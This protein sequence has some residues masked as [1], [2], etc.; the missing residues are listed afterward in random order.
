MS[1][2]A[3]G[4]GISQPSRSA[5]FEVEL[6]VAQADA[7]PDVRLAAVSP[8]ARQLERPSVRRQVR[9]LLRVEEELRR[10]LAAR[11][12]LARLPRLDVR[13]ELRPIE[14]VAGVEQQ[15]VD[16]LLRQ[17]PR[18]HAARRA[19]A[20]DDDRDGPSGGAM[21]CMVP[22]MHQNVQRRR[23]IRVDSRRSR[24]TLRQSPSSR[25][26]T[27]HVEKSLLFSWR[28]PACRRLARLLAQ[29]PARH[30]LTLDDIGRLAEVRDPQCSPDGTS[31]AFVVSHDRR[32]GRQEQRRTSGWSASTARTIGR[33]RSARTASRRRGGALT[34]ST[35]RS[36]R[37][38]PGKAKGNQVWLLDR[39]GGE[40]FQL[41]ELKGR[42]QGYEWSPDAKRLALVVGDPDPDADEPVRRRGAIRRPRRARAEADRDR[43]LQVQA[44]RPGLSAV[45]PS[46]LHLPVRHR[47]EEARS[48]DDGQGRRGVAVVVARRD[49]HR[50]HEQ[51]QRGSRSRAV[52]PALRR[53]REARSRPRRR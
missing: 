33:S 3:I 28:S 21:I 13:P 17:V 37:R 20:D 12:A 14:L 25:R 23:G 34:A 7:A 41:T 36:L 6:R 15:D 48:P 11:R 49:A 42:L 4:H 32:E 46:Q 51:P 35:C 1:L 5:A 47:D 30:P 10:S 27:D 9:L 26:F 38:G 39:N 50:L 52:E 45:G 19:A 2:Y 53:R 8:D 29:T 16:A 44:G 18:R 22:T 40:A 43:S 24:A 31:V